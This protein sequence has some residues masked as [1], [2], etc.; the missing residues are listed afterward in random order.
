MEV[1]AKDEDEDEVQQVDLSIDQIV[2]GGAHE[3]SESEC[4]EP[5][6]VHRYIR[7]RRKKRK[8]LWCDADFF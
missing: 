3:K 8:L 1:G 2:I 4:A 6:Q 5:A 7:S